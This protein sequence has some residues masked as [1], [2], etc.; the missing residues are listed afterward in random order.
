M[1]DE[2]MVENQP[3][4][5]ETAPD[6]DPASDA[7]APGPTV[8]IAFRP[9]LIAT[10]LATGTGPTL[11]A[12]LGDQI[13]ASGL[14]LKPVHPGATDAQLASWFEVTAPDEH[15]ARRA[16]AWLQGHP[17]V[18]AAFIKPPDALPG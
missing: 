5:P 3:S 14:A 2:T 12:E 16:Q 15:E 18:V 11:L 9:D 6:G 17:A 7:A 8:T 4:P 13:I 10:W 1:V